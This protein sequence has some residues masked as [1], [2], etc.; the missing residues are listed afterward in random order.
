MLINL[1]THL[2]ASMHCLQTRAQV[3]L[4]MVFMVR[5]R[6]LR[7]HFA[8]PSPHK[9]QVPRGLKEEALLRNWKDEAPEHDHRDF[10]HSTD[11]A[12]DV[13]SIVNFSFMYELSLIQEYN[14]LVNEIAVLLRVNQLV[15]SLA[16]GVETTFESGLPEEYP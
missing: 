16:Y 12:Q 11:I 7:E 1:A 10:E 13:D 5:I 6:R 14:V 9:I 4:E 8:I 2:A 15:D 3:L